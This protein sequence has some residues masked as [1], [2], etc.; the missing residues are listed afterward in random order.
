MARS[1]NKL[2]DYEEVSSRSMPPCCSLPVIPDRPLEDNIDPNREF[3]IRYIEKNGL[4]IRFFI[5]IFL[6]HL[7]HGAAVM[8]KNKLLENRLRNG[9]ILELD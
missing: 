7:N 2:D 5:I 9:K 4:T 3:L 1:K 8:Y 6:I